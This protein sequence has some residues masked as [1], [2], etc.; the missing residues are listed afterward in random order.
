M[1]PLGR[2]VGLGIKARWGLSLDADDHSQAEERANVGVRRSAPSRYGTATS[3]TDSSP[4]ASR[5]AGGLSPQ[6]IAG[7][8]R[9]CISAGPAVSISPPGYKT[10]DGSLAHSSL[11]ISRQDTDGTSSTLHAY[12]ASTESDH[13]DGSD[14]SCEPEKQ[15]GALISFTPVHTANPALPYPSG[16]TRRRR[17]PRGRDWTVKPGN[18]PYALSRKMQ[19]T[20][21]Y[22]L[23]A[24]L[25]F[26]LFL[27][28]INWALPMSTD[29]F[30]SS[31]EYEL[32][33][34]SSRLRSTGSDWV[35]RVW[36]S[37]WG[38]RAKHSRAKEHADLAFGVWAPEKYA[39]LAKAVRQGV[40]AG[41]STTVPPDTRF[42]PP[43]HLATLP[44]DR[45]NLTKA[46]LTEMRRFRRVNLWAAPEK[47]LKTVVLPPREGYEHEATV[48]FLHGLDQH[49]GHAFMPHIF[50]HMHP[51]IRFVMPQG[52]SIRSEAHDGAIVSGWFHI[53]SFP[54]DPADRDDERLFAAARGLKSIIA[55]ERTRLIRKER[56]LQAGKDPSDYEDDETFGTPDERRRAMKRIFLSGFSQGSVVSLLSAFT[57]PEEVGG[58]IVLSGFLPVRTDLARLSADLD[59]TEL[60]IFW[61]HGVDDEFCSFNDAV[62]S[63]SL[64]S[65]DALPTL[66]YPSEPLPE[67]SLFYTNPWYRLNNVRT[68]F[69]FYDELAHIYHVP[70]L[71]D[72]ERWFDEV[73]PPE[74]RREG[75]V[76]ER[77][78]MLRITG[79][80]GRRLRRKRF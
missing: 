6:G 15:S 77:R 12:D 2:I 51:K 46:E 4:A 36:S 80:N 1:T 56:G 53:K 5:S 61:G 10:A 75:K 44:E 7:W 72:L 79:P 21:Q 39:D 33:T 41:P 60:P 26:V 38:R 49:V 70:L 68:T 71:Q 54:Y 22:W 42:G 3:G 48:I 78:H 37:A 9:R 30:P 13:S 66:F 69:R 45:L 58:V 63:M 25:F 34:L 28:I 18:S 11:P 52:P 65:P 55:Q 43:P 16:S 24:F 17:L 32:E 14:S 74:A 23:L 35:H 47:E 62:Q 64:L 40:E 76:P 31:V 19:K 8:M 57:H 73:L 59:R 50:S 27:Q 67:T 29:G 20:A